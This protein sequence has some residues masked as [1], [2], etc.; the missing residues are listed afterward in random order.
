M[1]VAEQ[2]D[3]NARGILVLEG[4][5]PNRLVPMKHMLGVEV[6]ESVAPSVQA[7]GC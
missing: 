2:R 3:A 6:I 5:L 1:L 4:S 7:V